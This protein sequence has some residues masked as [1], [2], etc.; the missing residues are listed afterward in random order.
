MQIH[1]NGLQTW[2]LLDTGAQVTCI[3]EKFYNNLS[4]SNIREMPTSNVY[5]TTAIGKKPITIKKQIFVEI[6][7]NEDKFLYSF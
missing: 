6:R 3:S 5:I 4:N 1:I 2:A 7:V